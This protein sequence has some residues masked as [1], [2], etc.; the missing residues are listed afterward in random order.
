MIQSLIIQQLQF[1]NSKGL[2]AFITTAMVLLKV[3]VIVNWVL[4]CFLSYDFNWQDKKAFCIHT[5]SF[6]KIRTRRLIYLFFYFLI[7]SCPIK[8]SNYK[9]LYG[10]PCFDPK[11]NRYLNNKFWV[12]W[13]TKQRYVLFALWVYI[14][15]IMTMHFIYSLDYTY[16]C[17]SL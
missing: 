10:T 6:F 12:L 9:G 2:S 14:G 13:T 16:D 1:V 4:G 7:R 15:N 11:K 8:N 5:W 3:K 17:G